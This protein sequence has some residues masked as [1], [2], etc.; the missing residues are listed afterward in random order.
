[1]KVP[2]PSDKRPEWIN[3]IV[4]AEGPDSAS[5]AASTAGNVAASMPP[6][7]TAGTGADRMMRPASAQPSTGSGIAL[8]GVA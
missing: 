3:C 2:L 1:M 8:V 7:A 6:M 5:A 4:S